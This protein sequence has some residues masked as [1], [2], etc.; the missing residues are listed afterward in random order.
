MSSFVRRTRNQYRSG[1]VTVEVAICLP[2]LFVILFAIY[3]FAH[4]NLAIHATESAAYEAARAAIVPGAT[5]VETETVAKNVLASVG[6]RDFRMDISPSLSSES[7]TVRVELHVP[8]RENSTVLRLF[9]ANP[10]FHGRCEL[11]RE[12]F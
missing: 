12:A 8:F 6:I 9:V 10:V 4:V 2:V 3:E 1:A 11:A 5:K 7:K